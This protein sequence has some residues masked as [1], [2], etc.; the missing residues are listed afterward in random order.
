M[1]RNARGWTA[2]WLVVFL[3]VT[4]WQIALGNGV[5]FTVY[6]GTFLIGLS[7]MRRADNRDWERR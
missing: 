3:A 5:F 1:T 4:I 2:L 6:A 7:L